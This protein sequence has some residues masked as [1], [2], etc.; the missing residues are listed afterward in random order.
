V[1]VRCFVLEDQAPARRVIESY[2]ARLPDFEIVGSA[3]VP[4]A[5][6]DAL[7]TDSVDLLFLDLGLPQQDGFRFLEALPSPPLVVVTTAFGGRALE[8]FTHGVVDYLVK[9]FAF[10]R[11]RTATARA[12]LAL[13]ARHDETILT[14]PVDRDRREYVRLRDVTSLSADG[15]YVTIRTVGGRLYTAGPLTRWLE[16]LPAPPFVRVHRSHAVNRDHVTAATGRTVTVDGHPL[17]VSATCAADLQ[18]ALDAR[19]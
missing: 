7:A 19:R 4:A 9:P 5:A 14:V 2:C 17:P 15:D 11:F 8:G 18:R 10:E 16:R 1:T 6:S 13:R 3:A 12:R